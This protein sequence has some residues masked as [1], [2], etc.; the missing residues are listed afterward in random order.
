MAATRVAQMAAVGSEDPDSSRP[1]VMSSA[2]VLPPALA[3]AEAFASVY[4][5]QPTSPASVSGMTTDSD[6]WR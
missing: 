3:A 6:S 5:G 2:D 1:F 4:M